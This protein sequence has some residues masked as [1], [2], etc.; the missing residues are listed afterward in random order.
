MFPVLITTGETSSD[1]LLEANGL[2]YPL[3]QKPIAPEDLRRAIAY[4]H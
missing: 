3:L 4:S 2:R 1:A